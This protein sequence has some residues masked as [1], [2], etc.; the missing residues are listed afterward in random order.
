MMFSPRIW[1]DLRLWGIVWQTWRDWSIRLILIAILLMQL[2]P[3][4]PRA[5]LGPPQT[6]Q[7]TQP[8]LCMHTRLIDEVEEWKIQRTLVMVREMG[9]DTIVEFFPWAYIERE[10]GV[11][12]WRQADRIIAHAQNQGLQVI[13]R[14]GMVPAWAR[15]EPDPDDPASADTTLNYLEAERFPDFAHFAGVFAARYAGIVDTIIIWNEPNL[16]FEWGY[17]QVSPEDYTELLRQSYRAIKT[18][19]PETTVLAAPMAPTLEPESSPWG[20]ND[21]IFIERMYAAGVG[22]YS[23]AL[24]VHTYGFTFPPEAEPAA[25]AL[26]FRRIEL[27][28]D[29]MVRHGHGDQA[30]F[31]TETGWNDHPRWT[32]AVRPIQ[33][34]Q[35]TIDSYEWAAN[36]MPYVEQ[37]CQWVMRYPAP[38][39]SYPDYFTFVT[40][41]FRPRPIYEYLQ[42]YARGEAITLP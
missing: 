27:I 5:I 36:H 26:N 2:T 6:V 31:I 24:A 22:D 39:N 33:R 8:L 41:D 38:T 3:A 35:Y 15:P 17:R 11:Y 30:I 13:A 23:D 4:P 37:L 40:P 25:D 32:K 21:L 42:A 29:I 9:A 10:E 12:K 34:I 14:L 1:H 28:R 7:T 20:L 16:T 18:A 19:S